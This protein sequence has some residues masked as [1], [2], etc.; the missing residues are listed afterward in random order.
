MHLLSYDRSVGADW[1]I[2]CV[3]VWLGKDDIMVLRSLNARNLFEYVLEAERPNWRLRSLL[4]ER[5]DCLE[6]LPY[7]KQFAAT[8]EG[9]R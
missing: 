8:T 9:S 4:R 7:L 1:V 2:E 3:D 5:F 6:A